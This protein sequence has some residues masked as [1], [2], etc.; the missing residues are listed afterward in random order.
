MERRVK[1]TRFFRNARVNTEKIEKFTARFM[2]KITVVGYGPIGQEIVTQLNHSGYNP[3]IIESN[4]DALEE[5]SEG[6]SKNLII[7]GDAS[8][9]DILN[10]V[11]MDTMKVLAITT[12]DTE[13][14]RE[15]IRTARTINP[16]IK[17]IT[18]VQYISEESDMAELGVHYVCSER[19]SLNAFVSAI[20]N[21][22]KMRGH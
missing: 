20:S 6:E 1:N 16:E 10:A 18:R 15:I 4:I 11:H 2:P 19:E 14:A 3:V 13:K 8:Q 7:F 5:A 9:T 22:I 21:L 12:P 17:I